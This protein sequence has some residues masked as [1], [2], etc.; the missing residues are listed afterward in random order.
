[1][2]AATNAAQRRIIRVATA[3]KNFRIIQL[4]TLCADEIWF[5]DEMA[6]MSGSTMLR[7]K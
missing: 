2:I 5:L 6:R 7:V 1:M 4:A 3:N